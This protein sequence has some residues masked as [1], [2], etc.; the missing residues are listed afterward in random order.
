MCWQPSLGTT[1]APIIR[2]RRRRGA[3]TTKVLTRCR[4][5][6]RL[7]NFG[8]ANLI[9]KLPWAPVDAGAL[10]LCSSWYAASWFVTTW[11]TALRCRPFRSSVVG[12]VGNPLH[13]READAISFAI[14]AR[15]RG[16]EAVELDDDDADSLAR[17]FARLAQGLGVAGAVGEALAVGIIAGRRLAQRSAPADARLPRAPADS[18][19]PDSRSAS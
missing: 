16:R 5:R 18:R 9:R 6:A 17:E 2:R 14:G 7:H 10:F 15:L 11:W 13:T 4:R 19:L 12:E 8:A 3:A 1:L